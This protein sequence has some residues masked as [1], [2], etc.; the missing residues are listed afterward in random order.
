MKRLA[1]A[2][3]MAVICLPN[4]GKAAY[5]VQVQDVSTAAKQ[6]IS[7]GLFDDAKRNY[8]G[9]DWSLS[10]DN[11]LQCREWVI[12]LV[13]GHVARKEYGAAAKHLKAMKATMTAHGARSPAACLSE[14]I[15]LGNNR[16]YWLG[17]SQTEYQIARA[18]KAKNADKLAMRAYLC[19]SFD[20]RN[21]K[22]KAQGNVA[23]PPLS[24]KE[25][26]ST[27]KRIHGDSS[28][29]DVAT[30]LDDVLEPVVKIRFASDVVDRAKLSVLFKNAAQ[31][32]DE[33]GLDKSFSSFFSDLSEEYYYYA[34][35]NAQ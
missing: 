19:A 27:I 14:T 4:F 21:F 1:A 18:M 30:Y 25:F 26:I 35:E 24:R 23:S 9:C 13:I 6:I 17:Y 34:K 3:F 16:Y 22:F 32:C 12:A 7:L 28:E 31:R 5:P 15:R 10:G 20:S 2:A 29:F 8:G 33:L 11:Y